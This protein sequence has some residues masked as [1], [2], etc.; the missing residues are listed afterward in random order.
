VSCA[1]ELHTLLHT[2]LGRREVE[3][4]DEATR[5]TLRGSEQDFPSSH[6]PT[7]TILYRLGVT[8]GVGTGA[9]PTLA[10]LLIYGLFP[11]QFF[12]QL[13]ISVIVHG[14]DSS[15]ETRFIDNQTV[16]GSIPEMV[17]T[18]LSVL[19]RNLAVRGSAK[20]RPPA[21]SSSSLDCRAPVS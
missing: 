16:R 12:P 11:Q 21:T 4:E 5:R 19:R 7:T 2:Q 18:T 13:M 6:N 15:S 8:S 9:P 20:R 14:P 10:G 17:E 1:P 3:R